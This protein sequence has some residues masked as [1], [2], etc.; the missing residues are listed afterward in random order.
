[1]PFIAEERARL[2]G[3][4]GASDASDQLREAQRLYAAVGA[5]GHVAR[6]GG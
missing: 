3:A 5:T 4:L 6:L 2:A 1:V